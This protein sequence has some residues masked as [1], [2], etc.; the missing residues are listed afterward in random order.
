MTPQKRGPVSVIPSEG[1]RRGCPG[2][3]W[4]TSST[5]CSAARCELQPKCESQ[6]VGCESQACPAIATAVFRQA[7][8][9]VPCPR[10]P[11]AG[12]LSLVVALSA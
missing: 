4:T 5:A 8:S 9:A 3:Q 6:R 12:L 7:E 10:P 2:A 1:F 11:W